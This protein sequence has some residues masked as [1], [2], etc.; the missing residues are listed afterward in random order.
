MSPT[1][2]V[3][4]AGETKAFTMLLSAPNPAACTNDYPENP[5]EV[6]V[7]YTYNYDNTPGGV[8][9]ERTVYMINKV[10]A[11]LEHPYKGNIVKWEK[12]ANAVSYNVY[13]KNPEELS[14]TFLKTVL[15]NSAS[16]VPTQYTLDRSG[17]VR[18]YYQ[19][20][21]IFN[22]GTGSDISNA[23]RSTSYSLA[24]CTIQGVIVAIDG[25][26]I[27]DAAIA[28]RVKTAPRVINSAGIYAYNQHTMTN[29]DGSF[30]INA[31]QGSTIVLTI[32]DIGLR[33]T[34]L[35]PLAPAIDF[36]EILELNNSE[37]LLT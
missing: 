24:L 18:S 5:L 31:P 32:D 28:T 33:E 29:E 4:G 36:Q 27:K 10:D 11:T 17:Q 8:I 14:Y 12:V 21:A 34:L 9:T 20:S 19:I 37:V 16:E 3:I 23:L 26:P 6:T 7:S 13:R 30:V 1:T 2:A 22:D 35:V 25:R 15:N